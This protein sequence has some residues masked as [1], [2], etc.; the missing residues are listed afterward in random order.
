MLN[1]CSEDTN[2]T[3]KSSDNKANESLTTYVE[4][5]SQGIIASQSQVKVKLQFD[6]PKAAQQSDFVEISPK[7]D[8][9][10]V[11]NSD[12]YFSFIATNGFKNGKKYDFKVNLNTLLP[13]GSAKIPDLSFSVSIVELSIS[14]SLDGI[15][16]DGT[17]G[18]YEAHGNIESSDEIPSEQLQSIFTAKLNDTPVPFFLTPDGFGKAKISV[19]DIER[20]S[21]S[22]TLTLSWDGQ[23][24]GVSGSGSESYVIPGKTEFSVTKI[25]FIRGSNPHARI[26]FSDP[27][28]IKQY[29]KGIITINH[30]DNL[31]FE[32]KGNLVLAYPRSGNS[33]LDEVTVTV[34][35]TLKSA[36]NKTLG[37]VYEESFTSKQLSPA[38]ELIGEGVILPKSGSIYVPFKAAS[39][40]KIDVFVYQIFEKNI[41]QFLQTNRISGNS[42]LVRVGKFITSKRINLEELGEVSAKKWNTYNLDLKSVMQTEPGAIY[43]LEFRFQRAFALTECAENETFEENPLADGELRPYFESSYWDYEDSYYP[44]GFSWAQRDNP[45]NISYYTKNRFISRN[46]YASDVSVV[47]KTSGDKEVMVTVTDLA[48]AQP[49]EGAQV[50]ILNYPMQV[51]GSHST[52][53]DGIVRIPISD[54]P[55]MVQAKHS[56]QSG[57]VTMES[58]QALAMSSFDV[59]GEETKQGIKGFLYGERGVWRPGDSLFISFIIEDL[60]HSLPQNYPVLFELMNPR[61][62]LVQKTAVTQSLN[63]HY[64]F[65][66]KTEPTA[67]TGNYTVQAKVGNQMFSKR[68]KIETVKPN[69]LKIDFQFANEAITSN[70]PAIKGL[71]RSS[72][73]HGAPAADLQGELIGNITTGSAHFDSYRDFT[74]DDVSSR[75][76]ESKITTIPFSLSDSGTATINKRIEVP[77]GVPGRLNVDLTARVF[78]ESGDFS[79]MKFSTI[80][81]PYSSYVGIRI[82][83]GD[84]RNMLLT[85]TD[86]KVNVVVLTPEGE[87]IRFRKLRFTVNKISWRW[88]YEKSQENISDY[89]ERMNYQVIST[90][91]IETDAE[92][93]STGILAIKYPDWGRYVIKVTDEETGVSASSVVYVDWPGWAGKSRDSKMGGANLVYLN[94]PKTDYLTGEKISVQLPAA[95]G[96]RV[97]VSLEKADRVMRQFWVDGNGDQTQFTIDATDDLTPNFYV[98]THVIQPFAKRNG[99]LPIRQYG[100]LSI[101]VENPK[102]RLYPE[103]VTANS[104]EPNQNASFTISEKNGRKMTYTLAVVEDGLLDLTRFKTPVPYKHFYQKEAL[105]VKTWDLYNYVA[106]SYLS[107]SVKV[108]SLGGSDENNIDP[109]KKTV[110]RFDPV[111]R[112]MGPFELE[113][114]KKVTHTVALPNYVGS[115]R[116]MVV[117]QQDGAYGNTEV[118]RPVKKPLMAL[119]TAPRIVSMNEQFKIPVTVFSMDNSIQDVEVQ[120]ETSGAV[121]LASDKKQTVKFNNT[122]SQTV[123]FD[124]KTDNK[125]G[126]SKIEAKATGAGF[127]SVSVINLEVKNGFVDVV[128][129]KD[130]KLGSG[131]SITFTPPALG[132]ANTQSLTLN[133]STFNTVALEHRF[134]ELIEYPFGCLEQITT[135]VFPQLYLSS[136]R[137]LSTEESHTIQR[138]I[139]AAIAR[140]EHYLRPNGSLGYWPEGSAYNDFATAYAIHFLLE[141]QS[142][143]YTIP[144]TMLP[145]LKQFMS[146]QASRW[147]TSEYAYEQINQAYWLYVLAKQQSAEIGAMNRLRETQNL[148]VLASWFLAAAYSKIGQ[149]AAATDI[150][151]RINFA[152]TNNRDENRH[153]YFDSEF[154]NKALV[155]YLMQDM[156]ID[157]KSLELANEI[158]EKLGKTDY[159]NTQ[160]MGFGILS[161]AAFIK[162]NPVTEEMNIRWES[163]GKSGEIKANSFVEVLKLGADSWGNTPVSLTNNSKTVVNLLTHWIGK[164]NPKQVVARSRDIFQS[165]AYKSITGKPV[166]VKSLASGETF[167]AEIT[168]KNQSSE[169]LPYLALTHPIPSGWEILNTAI[170]DS[171]FNVPN[172]PYEFREVKDDAVFTYFG[173]KKGEEKTFRVLLSASYVGNYDLMPIKTSDLYNANRF[174][175]SGTSTVKVSKP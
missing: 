62:Q 141:A 35:S 171:Y 44:Q 33:N 22:Q 61:N 156:K 115:V 60:S 54:R 123:Y 116:T 98:H 166:D 55:W 50:E 91:S 146:Y 71:I 57:F 158:S 111:V 1:A 101:N 32:L 41:P 63:G 59:S 65:K 88:W 120:L 11:W 149:D 121:Q 5:Y 28:D 2:Q 21:E 174:A 150:L 125:F 170:D 39:L 95:Q 58:N 129:A 128:E 119:A 117:A 153:Y 86:H 45:C 40:K 23:S 135:K 175:M 10:L 27:V 84:K 161:L 148:N 107:N 172:S 147:N 157:F 173:L 132:L 134:Q 138:H 162:N 140:M 130:F 37:K 163:G 105:T 46:V 64:V 151:K 34:N 43:R 106:D 9:K 29:L 79:T 47:A 143:G 109:N 87:P 31:K 110:N 75:F 56:G 144:G 85:D 89:F 66:T 17:T 114:G 52:N 25:E 137:T 154:R 73:L 83:E 80:Y 18:F 90:Q 145:K 30:S 4:S 122:G 53:K 103:I 92:G 133:F 112:F 15:S 113:A 97:L 136:F 6:V 99:D 8:G 49:I 26:I 108:I 160:E 155:L 36:E 167:V 70:S 68:L 48:T 12:R 124:V 16:L 159:L 169:S 13:E 24:K 76:T 77:D 100:V 78:E 14:A 20:K 3:K 94:S 126:A 51:I 72:W 127:E 38:L 19:P 7:I 74:F 168:V 142:L 42:D 102:S 69:R 165:I 164:Q 152:I 96:S 81:H 131:E 104:F 93:N 82:P 139:D 67:T 118:S